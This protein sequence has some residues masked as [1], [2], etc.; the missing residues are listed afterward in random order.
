M[1]DNNFAVFILSHGRADNVITYKTL[2][3]HGY[4]GEIYI[5]CDDGDLQLNQYK[6]KYGD[7]VIVF[8]KSEIL[9][10]FDVGDN[11]GKTNAIVFAR[12]ASFD[13]AEKLGIKYFIELDDDYSCFEFRI[14]VDGRYPMR[15]REVVNLDKIFEIYLH[16]Y[17]SIN[18]KSLALSQGGDYI[19]GSDAPAASNKL[20]RKCMNSFFCSTDR[21]FNF[22]GFL[23]EDVTTYVLAQSKGDLFLT[24]PVVSIV[25]NNTQTN[26]G[27][28]TDIYL[29]CGTYRKSFYSVMFCPSCVRI[30][31]MGDKH[32][33]L[34]HSVKWNNAVPKIISP[35][36]KLN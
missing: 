29:Q 18:A 23:N 11:F 31:K 6:K 34:H 20:M 30:K 36:Y 32:Y 15:I 33:R 19:G 21:R 27:G 9:K 17:I 5:I 26:S 1:S 14:G 12:N 10:T 13:I 7:K 28:M 22:S 2:R 4:T 3:K 8:S 24:A 35:K 25:Q 16:Y